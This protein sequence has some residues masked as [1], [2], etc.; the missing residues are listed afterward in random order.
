M[1]I[2]ERRKI[3]QDVLETYRKLGANLIELDSLPDFSIAGT[4]SFIL[5]TESAASFDD[6]TRSGEAD[7]LRTG[8]SR[9]SWPNT[10]KAGRFVPAVEYIRAQRAR[11]LLM[12]QMDDFM[13]KYDALLSAGSD[14]TLSVT[15]LTGH[16]AMALKCGIYNNDTPVMIML[17]GRLY[18]EATMARIALAY[19]QAT[20][21]KDRHPTLA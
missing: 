11:V 7:L 18:E 8:T 5:Q 1:P 17:T 3:Y 9:S 6:L 12:R 2:E 13:S 21:W 10:F 16:P 19:E 14:S 4:I 15:N 20:E